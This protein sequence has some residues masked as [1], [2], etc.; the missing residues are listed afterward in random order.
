MTRAAL[1]RYRVEHHKQLELLFYALRN[2]HQRPSEQI[3]AFH[4]LADRLV[5]QGP[6]S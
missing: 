3:R 6:V 4:R 1:S 5:R 2:K